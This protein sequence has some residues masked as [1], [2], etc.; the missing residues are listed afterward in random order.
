MHGVV[1][2]W[3]RLYEA[4]PHLSERAADRRRIAQ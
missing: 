1:T 2:A 3:S 4:A